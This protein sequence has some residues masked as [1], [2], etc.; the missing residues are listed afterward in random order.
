MFYMCI[1]HPSSI[2]KQDRT[3][4]FQSAGL[5]A[6]PGEGGLCKYFQQARKSIPEDAANFTEL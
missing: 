2:R 4:T 1:S 6:I 5:H 3:T